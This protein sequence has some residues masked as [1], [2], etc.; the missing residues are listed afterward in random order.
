MHIS[1]PCIPVCHA[2]ADA[3][4]LRRLRDSLHAS[5][6]KWTTKFTGWHPSDTAH[7]C[8]WYGVVCSAQQHVTK[9]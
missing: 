9:V 5:D 8:R 7:P 1:F 4:I 3:A 2:E 6:P